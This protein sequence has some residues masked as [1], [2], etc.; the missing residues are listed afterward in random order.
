MSNAAAAPEALWERLAGLRPRLREGVRVHLHRYRRQRWFVLR[1]TTSGGWQRISAPAY[2][3]VRLFDGRRRL[4]DVLDAARDEDSAGLDR[5]DLLQVVDGLHRAELLDWGTPED[6]RRLHARAAAAAS[7]RRLGRLLSPLAWRV[8]LLD[9]DTLL[10]RLADYAALLFSRVGACLVVAILAAGAVTAF[11]TWPAIAGYWGARG[12]TA[13]SFVLLPLA[14]LFM[15]TLHELAHALAVKRWG[16]EVHEMGVVFLLLM[17]VPYVDASAAWAF[18]DKRRR[19]LVGA[20]GILVELVLA[21]VGVLVF[22]VVESGPVRDF[23]YTV[24]LLGGVSTLVFN[25]NP[26]LR[27]D[28]YYVLAD[29]LE[30]PNLGPRASR[31]WAYLVQRYAFGADGVTSPVTALGERRW[32]LCYGAASTCYRIMIVLGIALLIAE[33]VPALGMVLAM[34][35]LLGQVAW[36]L[37][38][39]TLAML[40]SPALAACRRRA[41]LVSAAVASLTATVLFAVPL[42][43]ST[44]AEGVVWLPERARVRA[45]ADGE[46]AALLQPPAADVAAGTPLLTL[47]NPLIEARIAA[48]EWELGEA[49]A[50]RSAARVRDVVQVQ[51]LAAEVARLEADLAELR[52]EAGE[53]VVT[54]PA[55]GRL[56]VPAANELAGRYLRKGD[57]VAYVLVDDV[58]T[59]R[60][61]IPQADAG[62]LR[63]H[64]RA[65]RVRLVDEPATTYAA[66]IGVEVPAATRRLPS[67]ALGA[68]GGGRLAVDG[69]DGDGLTA[70]ERLFLLDLS[71]PAHAPVERVGG[72]ALV[73]FEHEPEPLALRLYRSLRRLL[74]TRL[75][76]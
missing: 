10:E 70:A 37:L 74:L 48:L 6:P 30:I 23:S 49:R 17:P 46:V 64:V 25:G 1:D 27:F 35:V 32:F 4:A 26:L 62:R 14:Y 72:R 34:W 22:A 13:D 68:R 19:M 76:V 20:A 40:R 36:P 56:V 73:R 71:L 43:L 28:G 15:K 63:G 11:V 3:A 65:V 7:R 29:A 39:G 8:P 18:A 5:E 75:A 59:V 58:P 38:R 69:E 51:V 66:H 55:A 12:F 54:S 52:R 21:A 42:P 16:G 53:L 9:P 61:A 57:V 31:Y 67:A 33:M 2:R 60:V 44:H 45:A 47:D 24:M 50:R 41:V